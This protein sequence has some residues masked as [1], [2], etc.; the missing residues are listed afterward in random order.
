[1]AIIVGIDPSSGARSKI[2][3]SIFDSETN[4]IQ[5]AGSFAV[6]VEHTKTLHHRVRYINRHMEAILT[7]LHPAKQS[8]CYIEC[9]VMRGRGGESLARA[10]GALLA[11]V[12]YFCE[13][14]FIFNTTTKML[15]G[16][17][18]HAEKDEV[19]AGVLNW[20]E[21]SDVVAKLIEEKDWDAIDSLAVGVA[22]LIRE[23]Q[24]G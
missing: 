11:A 4:K 20:F 13:Q 16:G 6:P 19:A 7:S 1:M 18:G 2:G 14:E 12:P 15:V 3:Y 8:F 10:T 21:G 24:E 9:T 23:S 17:H 5:L 22:G